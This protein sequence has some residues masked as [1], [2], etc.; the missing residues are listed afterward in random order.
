MPVPKRL[1]QRACRESGLTTAA[2]HCSKENSSYATIIEGA[3]ACRSPRSDSEKRIEI[4]VTQDDQDPRKNEDLP[5]SKR[6]HAFNEQMA[7]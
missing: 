2:G 1:W 5:N 6:E 4:H 7:Q 3:E